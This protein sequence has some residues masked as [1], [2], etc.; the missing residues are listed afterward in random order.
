[1]KDFFI[2]Y[3]SADKA[4]AEWIAWVLEEHGY[5]VI[6]QA[7][8]FRPGGNFILDMQRA[9]TDAQRTVMV[10]SEN[11]LNALYTQPK[12]AAAFAQDPTSTQRKLL[13]IR[14][15][16]CQPQGMLRPLGYV[17][18]VDKSETEAEPLLLK[19]LQDRAKPDTRPSFPQA[20]PATERV[21]AA[22][23]AYPGGT[24]NNLPRSGTVAFVGRDDDLANLHTQLHQAN[25]LAI[26]AIQGIGGIGKTE[27]ALQ[28]A[29]HHRKQGTYPGGICWLQVREQEVGSQI[30][31]F[32]LICLDLTPP[33]GLELDQQVQ[34]CWQHWPSTEAVLIIYDD[35]AT[36]EAIS[37]YL[38]PQTQQ[39]CVLITTRRQFTG[40]HHLEIDVLNPEA[41][42]SLL[43]SLVGEDR[44]NQ[45]LAEAEAL[46]QR[47]GYLPLA[48]ELVGHYLQADAD[49]AIAEVQAE[50][51]AMRTNAYAL[52]KDDSAGN[53]TA[54][55]GVAEAFELSM[56]RLDAA[57]ETLAILLSLFAATPIIWQW[58]Q[59]CLPDQPEP[60]LR[61]QRKVLLQNSLLQRV[62]AETYQLHPLIQE[63]LRVRQ[64]HVEDADA[65]KRQYTQSLVQIAQTIPQTPTRDQILAVTAAIPHLAEAATTWQRWLEDDSLISP[66]VGLGWFYQ[67]QG[68]YGQ[69]EPWLQACL[70]VTRE[71]LGDAHPHVAGSLNNLALLYVSQGRY[72]EAEPLFRQALAL[73]QRLLGDDHP[74]VATSLNNLA[75]LYKSQGRYDEAEPLFHQA[76][77]LRQRLLGNEHPDV[78][79][80][81][82][83]LAELYRSQG[84]YGE[85]EPLYR[86]ALTL[87]QRLLGDAHPDVA[88]SLHNLAEL[89]R[90]QGRYGE[91]EPLY[92]QAL[93]LHQRLLG[94]AHPDVA[95]SLNNLAALY[96]SQGRY[97]EAE[98]LFRQ[99]LSLYQRLLGDDHP[100]VASSLNN[101]ALLYQLQGRYDEAEPLYRQALTLHQRLL[102]D[103]HPDVA[104]SLNNLAMLYWSQGCYDEAEPLL[105]QALTLR[106]RLLG[107]AHPDVAQSL[108]NLAMLYRS[109]GCYDEAEPLYLQ[110]LT[111]YQR[112]L[113]DA[114]P[115]VATSLHNLALLYQSQGR[116]GEAE[117]LFRQA[118]TLRQRL[119]GDE[120]PDVAR[121]LHNLAELYRSQGRYGEAEPLYLGAIVIGYQRLGENHPNT[122][123]F[124]GNFM[125]CLRAAHNAGQ[126]HTLSSHPTTQALLAQLQP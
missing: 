112:L 29:Q 105:H 122:Q 111:L 37:P 58:V 32:A 55:L 16:P 92:R 47:L 31:S 118:L 76:L 99:A 11:Y 72:D 86:Q 44:I 56:G 20:I 46:C 97:G 14:V 54:R 6:I 35:V 73:S 50:L 79:Q 60:T 26:T 83:N 88:T 126:A 24:I 74:A 59:A 70:T 61:N 53:M 42:L 1:V 8:D 28:Y 75:A 110:A 116:Y 115:D 95:G 57:S 18:L 23:V 121:S 3:N 27:L 85:A 66:F 80:S 71:R 102:G 63:F 114:H 9:A 17:D 87:R 91:A 12:W 77:T 68:A 108:N 38:P 65:L 100:H 113:G 4:W 22:A 101:L 41:A 43:R 78:A 93:T 19:A 48:L 90:S 84:R 109:Q 106:Q 123:T 69:A 13:P 119:L 98:P 62:G 36:F 10:L 45:Q 33:D 82:H 117:P 21:T 39:F 120:H 124:R 64:E 89:Y 67:G 5:T 30:V 125:G 40:I 25:R 104:G 52:I 81:L 107:D 103:E 34:W 15:A 7:W 51:D 94:D 96:A 2:S 49:L